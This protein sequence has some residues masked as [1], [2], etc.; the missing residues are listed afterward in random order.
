MGQGL[1]YRAWF[2]IPTIV[3]SGV[4]EILGWSGRLW[5]SKNVDLNTPFMI[6]FVVHPTKLERRCFHL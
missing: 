5:S 6:Q 3:F 2:V 1:L 4:L